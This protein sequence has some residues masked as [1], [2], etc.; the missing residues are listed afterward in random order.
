VGYIAYMGEKLNA[1]RNFVE[2]LEGE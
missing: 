1:Y 2:K